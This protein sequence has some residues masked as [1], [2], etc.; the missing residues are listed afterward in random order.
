MYI[1]VRVRVKVRVRVRVRVLGDISHGIETRYRRENLHFVDHCQ[2][3]LRVLPFGLPH[4]SIRGIIIRGGI[5]IRGI[6]IR[7]AE[8]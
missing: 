4:L 3:S 2:C 8:T 1:R 5:S 6:I 7:L